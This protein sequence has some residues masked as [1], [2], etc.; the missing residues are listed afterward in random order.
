MAQGERL[1]VVGGGGFGRE[2]ICWAEDCQAAGTLPPLGGFIDD[3]V[4]ALPGYDVSRVGTFQ[5]YSP[6]DGDLFVV[7]VGDPAKK[8]RMVESLKAR[9]A[10]FATLVHPSAT[11]VRTASMAEGVIMCPQTMMMPDSRA[12]PFVTIL[13]FSGIGHDSR[14]G[15]Y[16]TL[17]SLVDI[18]GNVTVGSEVFIG[19]GARLLPGIS[20]GDRAVI[21]AGATVV[22]SVKPGNTVY[23][24]P[25]KTLRMG[26]RGE[27]SE[28]EAP[29]RGI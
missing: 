19:A 27:E 15:A 2:I 28:G 3:A 22:R 23:S 21:G 13:N 10:S 11:V 24:V 6:Q 20:V 1:I 12:E 25:A 16:T 17:S 14:V 5:D 7:A 4:E 29:E 18:T 8:R 26:G 9:G